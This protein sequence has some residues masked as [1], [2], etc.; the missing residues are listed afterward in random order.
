MWYITNTH[1]I[2]QPLTNAPS[3][4]GLGFGKRLSKTCWGGAFD[5]NNL[6][7]MK[8]IT[9][10]LVSLFFLV[11]VATHAS[12]LSPMCQYNHGCFVTVIY[13]SASCQYWLAT[14]NTGLSYIFTTWGYSNPSMYDVLYGNW[15]SLASNNFVFD[16]TVPNNPILT[17]NVV[18]SQIYNS[19][20]VSAYKSYCPHY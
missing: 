16:L 17:V 12:T 4:N 1:P 5:I 14:D 6:L 13:K 15:T 3:Q 10:I 11:P 19:E 18:R 20:L 7:P 2:L 9:I 8:K